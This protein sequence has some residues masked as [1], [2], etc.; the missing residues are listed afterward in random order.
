MSQETKAVT[1]NVAKEPSSEKVRKLKKVDDF[2]SDVETKLQ[3]AWKRKEKRTSIIYGFFIR[4]FLAIFIPKLWFV[5]RGDSSEALFDLSWTIF[6]QAF[7]FWVFALPSYFFLKMC[8]KFLRKV[9][10]IMVGFWMMLETDIKK[11]FSFTPK[12]NTMAEKIK[13]QQNKKKQ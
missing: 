4:F 6:P 9:T 5:M 8:F 10:F 7:A 3:E 2:A 13:K 1:E 12:T 11:L